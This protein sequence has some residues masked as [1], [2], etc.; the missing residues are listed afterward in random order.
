[1]SAAASITGRRWSAFSILRV[2]TATVRAQVKYEMVRRV[3]VDGEGVSRTAATFGYSSWSFYE[4]A[5]PIDAGGMA[6]LTSHT[7]SAAKLSPVSTNS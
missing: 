6:A 4:A 7:S 5:A 2:G 3:C 1:M